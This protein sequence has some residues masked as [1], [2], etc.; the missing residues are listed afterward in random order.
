MTASLRID[1]LF[2]RPGRQAA[3]L[4]RPRPALGRRANLCRR[5]DGGEGRI[6]RRFRPRLT[7]GLDERAGGG[8]E[9]FDREAPRFWAEI[10]VGAA[11]AALSALAIGILL[12]AQIG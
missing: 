7:A 9:P 4:P 2:A 12:V 5:Q 6:P 1:G 8:L 10:P 11:A 3:A